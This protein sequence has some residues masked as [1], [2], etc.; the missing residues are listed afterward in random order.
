[1]SDLRFSGHESFACRYAWLPKAY[2]A[3]SE[4]P[5]AFADDERAMVQM[6]VGKNMV[7][8]IRFWIEATGVASSGRGRPFEVSAFGHAIFGQDGFDPYLEDVRTLWLLH[9]NLSSRKENAI[10]A[11]RYLLNHWPH[12]EL[13]RTDVLSAFRRESERLGLKHS[14]VTLS[15][16]LDVFLHTYV[17]SRHPAIAVEDSLDGPLV[18]L[19]LLECVGER[20]S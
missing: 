13:T 18:D 4:D 11:W 10:F 5:V 8:S 2:R 12:A 19:E 15:Q 3:I 14:D 7:R 1:M 17:P 6:G 9:W 16:H 20:R